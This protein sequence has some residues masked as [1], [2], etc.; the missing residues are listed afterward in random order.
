[1]SR[2]T[3]HPAQLK[4][5]P[6]PRATASRTLKLY[7]A[8]FWRFRWLTILHLIGVVGG[9]LLQNVL[10]PFLL[11]SGVRALPSYLAHGGTNFWAVFGGII[12][13]YIAAQVG[14]WV[15]WRLSGLALFTLQAR[16]NRVLE[17]R[18]FA[19]LTTLS[20]RFF[21]DTF[22]GALVAQATRFVG[23]SERLYDT[24]AFELMPLLLKV[25]VS[26]AVVFSFAPSLAWLILGFV[27]TFSTMII[28]LFIR[29]MPISER[30][31]AA[32]TRLTAQLADNVTNMAAIKYFAREDDEMKRYSQTGLVRYRLSVRDALF[33]ELIID[34]QS[35]FMTAF[36]ITVFVAALRLTAQHRIDL[37]QL[38]LVQSFLWNILISLWGVGRIVRNV[39]RTFSDAAEMTSILYTKPEVQ[40]DPAA[41]P[42]EI[43]RG[44][45]VF[46]KVDFAYAEGKKHH[47]VFKGLSLVIKPGEKVGLVGPSGGGKTTVT[48]L[49]LRLMDIDDGRIQLDGHTIAGMRQADVRRAISYVPQEPMLFHRSLRDNIAYGRP[50][51][52][53]AEIE[54][55]AHKAHAA[56]FIDR[57]PEGYD[58]MVGERGVKLSGGQRQR[59]A[60]A[61]AMLKDAPV[62][63]LDEATSALDSESERLIQDALW[64]LMEGRTAVVIAHRL[65]T[66]QH[67]DRIV[68]LEDGAIAEQGSH[69]ELLSHGGVYAR[70]W[71]HQSG[72]FIDGDGVADNDGAASAA[73]PI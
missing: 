20:Y 21:A 64:R 22:G 49:L 29:K 34:W 38:V 42:V 1:M 71:A 14:Q 18:I 13:L 12:T 30:A 66:I 10:V 45:V 3:L 37:G 60:I 27:V 8:A 65:S 43:T 56:E 46:D 31:A 41:R 9:V 16:V 67:M 52:T 54:A 4:T 28:W 69:A 6:K 11:A 63:V 25:T 17:E 51:A 73:A 5:R 39:E 48:K 72:G 2:S 50:G 55:A 44:E 33:S 61:R 68:V 19:H 47:Q 24:M 32:H 59:V 15:M 58:T 53:Q 57:L 26:F 36:E 70:L 7:A 62:L 35:L 23:A 40:D